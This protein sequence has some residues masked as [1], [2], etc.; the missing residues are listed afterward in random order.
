MFAFLVDPLILN[1]VQN[2]R[3]KVEST[4]EIKSDIYHNY[5]SFEDRP[6]YRGYEQFNDLIIRKRAELAKVYLGPMVSADFE[7]DQLLEILKP[8][9]GSYASN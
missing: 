7:Y 4:I 5:F 8:K 3:P 2:L 9:S 1:L 6:K